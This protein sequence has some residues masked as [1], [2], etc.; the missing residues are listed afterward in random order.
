MSLSPPP[1]FF[2]FFTLSTYYPPFY[3]TQNPHQYSPLILVY[4][5][6]DHAIRG[7][8]VFYHRPLWKA[9]PPACASFDWLGLVVSCFAQIN[10][11]SLP[12]QRHPYSHISRRIAIFV[13]IAIYY[14]LH[15]IFPPLSLL[16]STRCA[17]KRLTAT[18]PPPA[19]IPRFASLPAIAPIWIAMRL[20]GL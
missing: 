15:N 20:S 17:I 3:H 11:L 18:C 13:P 5:G 1:F 7:S 2:F 10:L 8:P 12:V 4:S 19:L 9:S 6:L 16:R 14:R